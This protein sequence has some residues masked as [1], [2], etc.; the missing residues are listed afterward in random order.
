MTKFVNKC[1]AKV[2]NSRSDLQNPQDPNTN[3]L[4][5]SSLHLNQDTRI[6]DEN[7]EMRRIFC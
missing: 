7:K 2:I 5:N 4:L 3:V 6:R 1:L